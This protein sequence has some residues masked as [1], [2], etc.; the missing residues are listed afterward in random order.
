MP[1]AARPCG[2]RRLRSRPLYSTLPPVRLS[3]PRTARSVD[4]LP[5]PLR[6]S[7]ATVSPAPTV[8]STPRST[9]TLP[10][11]AVM[12]STVST[13]LPSLVFR[14]AEIGLL[15]LRVAADL[16]R[17]AA[18][19]QRP[20]RHDDDLVGDGE[21]HLHVVLDQDDIDPFGNVADA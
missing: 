10:I 18:C 9:G 5:T 21:H 6:P 14:R 20:L 7:S 13:T 8:R 19:Q 12:P 15:N 1:S 4:V 17:S 3:S 2:G 11:S 16:C